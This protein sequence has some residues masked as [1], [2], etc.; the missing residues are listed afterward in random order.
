MSQNPDNSPAPSLDAARAAYTQ[1]RTAVEA[2]LQGAPFDKKLV[3]RTFEGVA[4]QPVYTRADASG[5]SGIASQPGEAPFLRGYSESGYT[6]GTWE[7]SQEIAAAKPLDFNCALLSDLMRG[8]NSI[9][10]SPD[11]A[12]RNGQDADAASAGV[13]VDGV[14]VSD[15]SDLSAALKGVDLSALPVHL[16]A[17]ANPLPVAALYLAYAAKNNVAAEKLTGSL[18]ADPLAELAEQGSLPI[19][20]DAAYDA[21]ATW[22]KWAGKNT[23]ELAT[24]GVNAGL[25]LEAGG[26]AVQELAFAIAAGV[27]YLRALEAR[28]VK[29][30]AVAP[31]IRF[32]FAV[33]PQFFLEVS[34]FRAFRSLWARVA[35]SYELNAK[36][37]RPRVHAR[38]NRWNKTVLDPHVNMLRV[39]TEAFSAV[40]G[41]ID[42]L[43]IGT[44][45][46]VLGGGDEFSRRIA[47]NLHTLLSEEFH[48]V[49]P[50]DPAGGSWLVEKTT[51]ELARKAWALFQDIEKQGGF[52]AALRSGYVQKL[53]VATAAEKDD[54]VSK[55]RL[56]LVGTNLFPNLKEKPVAKPA[57]DLAAFASA[58]ATEIKSR[59]PAA[60]KAAANDVDALVKAAAA[61][62][63]IG[64]LAALSAS[65]PEA[66]IA[67]VKP[68]RAAEGFEALRAAADA[69]AKKTGSRPKIFL[70]KIGP[71]KQ[72]KPRAD[73]SA[74]FFAVGGFESVGKE[75]F[76]T[77]EAAAQAAAT[78]GAPV[79]VLCSTDDTYPALVPVFAGKL[80]ALK[81]DITVVLAGL[82]ADKAVVDSFHAAGIDEFIHVRANVRELLAKL[83]KQIGA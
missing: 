35:Q 78:S 32:S 11:Q 50:V 54:A 2:E 40:L 56:G 53:V 10:L 24:V 8:Q 59:R 57:F 66:A 48:T 28:K 9:A 65:A 36:A 73:F 37:S 19:S 15:L 22:T 3:T 62:A 46:E 83:L 67:A 12:S 72:H 38:T 58:R 42:S 20:L 79:A 71:V 52:A 39:T 33:G 74:G 21:L 64:Q 55:R 51:D 18:T 76:E 17:G 7:F 29:A 49:A 63:T 1:W 68:K 82:P 5:L 80:K 43:H 70:A 75:A 44:F 41:G 31:K 45:D 16:R 6:A 26:N 81:P 13:G 47:R 69:F 4:L 77:A 60:P 34:K 23:P 27:E 14:S 30:S 61:G 25:W